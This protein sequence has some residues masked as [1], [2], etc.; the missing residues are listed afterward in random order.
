MCQSS[1]V[2]R[3]YAGQVQQLVMW[4]IRCRLAMWLDQIGWR[5]QEIAADLASN[6]DWDLWNKTHPP[7]DDDGK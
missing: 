5:L 4:K 7:K 1:K 6:A 3:A 2:D